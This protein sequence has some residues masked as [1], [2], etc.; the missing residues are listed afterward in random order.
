MYCGTDWELTFWEF[1]TAHVVPATAVAPRAAAAVPVTHDRRELAPLGLLSRGFRDWHEWED[2]FVAWRCAAAFYRR[3]KAALVCVCVCACVCIYI[4]GVALLPFIDEGRLLRCVC[5][6]VYVCVYIYMA[7][8]C[9]LTSWHVW[10]DLLTYVPWYV[11]MCD[12]TL[13]HVG[14]GMLT[15]VTRGIDVC[16]TNDMLT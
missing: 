3:G 6:C 10:L 5:V 9:C 4:Y 13:C 12:M 16:A 2:D 8:R 11:N 7:L 15:C 1:P 14:H